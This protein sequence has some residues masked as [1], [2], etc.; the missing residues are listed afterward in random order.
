MGTSVSP[1]TTAVQR[2][3]REVRAELQRELEAGA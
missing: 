2:E 3:V 1:W